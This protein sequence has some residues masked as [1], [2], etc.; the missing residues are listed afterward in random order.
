MDRHHAFRWISPVLAVVMLMTMLAVGPQPDV[1]LA[2]QSAS[3]PVIQPRGDAG[4][5]GVMP[6]AG[7]V[8]EPDILWEAPTNGIIMGMAIH[9]DLLTYTTKAGS[10][11]A[12]QTLDRSTG[13]E[14]WLV[15]FGEEAT[16]FGPAATGELFVVSVWEGDDGNAVVA[17]NAASGEEAWRLDM[18]VLPT[19]P[20]YLNGVVYVA[21]QGGMD[22]D[23]AMFA[24]DVASGDELWRYDAP[25]ALDLGESVA[26]ADGVVVATAWSL[27]DNGIGAYGF[28]A[29]TGEIIWT[30]TESDE[31]NFEPVVGDGIVLI[32]D[33]PFT[34]GLDL[35]TGEILWSA[36]VGGVGGGVAMADG[37]AYYGLED[38][39]RALDAATGE[40]LWTTAVTRIAG[41]PIVADG[42]VYTAVWRP[43]QERDS[44]Y[45]HALDAVT[46]DEVWQLALDVQ[47]NNNQPLTMDG[48]LFVD[49]DSGVVAFGEEGDTVTETPAIGEGG[50]YESEEFGYTVAWDAPWSRDEGQSLLEDGQDFITLE[51]GQSSVAIRTSL[52]DLAAKDLLDTIVANRESASEDV[53]VLASE[54]DAD[55]AT[56]TMSYIRDGARWIEHMEVTT[57]DDGTLRLV[58]LNAPEDRFP[59]VLALAL[60]T[61]TLDDEPIVTVIPAHTTTQG[62]GEPPL[63][64]S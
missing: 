7:P 41:A 22:G 40:E 29:E 14:I 25:E 17:L 30:F 31:L 45:L 26:V 19:A 61:I 9:G 36:R 43:S 1:A 8:D 56:A 63:S 32:T 64:S 49:S 53:E 37:I 3:E 13:D 12:I 35:E 4:L 16:V 11:G 18:D 27:E 20:T 54:G 5:S 10:Q 59:Y 55:V 33:L 51:L 48:V 23:S 21:A 57:V 15:E 38:E 46:G 50:T 60:G 28:D 6:G 34:W 52:L 44:H 62:I 24:L 42:V 2:V 39:V 58:I 47:V